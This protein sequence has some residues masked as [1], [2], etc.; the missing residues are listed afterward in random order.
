MQKIEYGQE[1]ARMLLNPK[2]DSN[3]LNKFVCCFCCLQAMR[4]EAD[5]DEYFF[6]DHIQRTH[7]PLQR[8]NKHFSCF[9]LVNRLLSFT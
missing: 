8:T 2:P 5:I 3:H 4:T 7:F 1:L 6:V 9:A